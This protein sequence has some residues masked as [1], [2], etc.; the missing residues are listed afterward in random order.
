MKLKNRIISSYVFISL[1]VIAIV[2]FCV[3]LINLIEE[4]YVKV[5]EETIPKIE[6]IQDLKSASLRLVS[7]TTEAAFINRVSEG[8]EA[9]EAMNTEKDLIQSGIIAYE[10][11]LAKY[12]GHIKL[13][14][15]EQPLFDGI[16]ENGQQLKA[17]S[18]KIITA[19][20]NG[21]SDSEIYELKEE[22][23]EYEENT[24]KAIDA[25][26]AH[27]GHEVIERKQN[28]TSVIYN[29]EFALIVIGCISFIIAIVFGCISSG[30]I[31][32]PINKLNDAM[33]EVARGDLSVKTEIESNDEIGNLS[34]S[35][36]KMTQNL[37]ESNDTIKMNDERLKLQNKELERMAHYDHLTQIPN[38]V[39][40]L[41]HVERLLQRT[42]KQ[43]DYL[44]AV[45]FIDLDR[46]KI[47]NDS[48][49]HAIG[50]ELLVEVAHRLEACTR[51]T[52]KI[53]RVGVN[54]SVARFGG[55]EFAVFLHDIKDISSA[56]RVADR[57]QAE[58]Q[59]PI[60]IGKHELYTSA[61][62]GIALSASGYEHA[63]DMLRDADAA[64]YRAK[65]TGKAHAEIFD[66]AM[67]KKVSEMLQL[68]SDLR[69]AVEVE[70]FIL[71]Y[72]PIVSTTDMRIRGAEALIRW[73]HPKKGFISP[74]DFIP[75]AEETG[76]ISDIGEWVFRTA[77]AQSKEWQDAGYSNLLMKVNF[78][79]RQFKDEQF[80]EMIK[81]IIREN[82][83]PAQLLD[84]EIT[85]SIAMEKGS[86]GILNEL[87]T[88]GLQ[89]SIDD[90]GTGYSSLG[91]LTKFPINTIKID[92][93]FIKEI[94]VD[95]NAEAIIKA[96][97]AMA[98]SLN[99]EVIAEGVETE[100][101]MS[102]LESQ[103]CEK[104]QGYLFSPPVPEEEF[105][106]LLEQEKNGS[107]IIPK[108]SASI[109]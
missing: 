11:S 45:L 95:I 43:S 14:P 20:A 25:A 34:R 58:L 31:S 92:R 69:F 77:C 52:D 101:Q 24:L 70:Q 82:E 105:R 16:K 63:D 102:Y 37:K 72:Q 98:H 2:F 53:S 33:E 79:S 44:F 38:R 50:D 41:S 106:K 39:K 108:P 65:A 47:I 51:A 12:E 94:A 61:S 18:I 32:R 57:I 97:I 22:F 21:A 60:L 87:T 23:E 4:R 7:S 85:E 55:D 13:F 40:F 88:M 91:S 104:M 64:M 71:Y 78:S 29:S 86:I 27:E 93:S 5:A 36:N 66:E 80:V 75:I 76:L 30:F 103:K 42:K 56:S 96:I 62:I 89:T 49:G 3:K 99:M 28:V 73:N 8:I 9:D 84:V 46:F 10:S 1:F 67:H 74:M 90:F 59:E 83:M 48:L 35:F 68:E 54:E 6:S 81:N 15:D 26:L 107:S 100:E 109:A 17:I 19:L